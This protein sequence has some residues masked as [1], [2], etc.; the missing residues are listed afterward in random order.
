MT[1]APKAS[2]S[3]GLLDIVIVRKM[4]KAQLPLSLL[5]QIAGN[6]RLSQ[7]GALKKSGIIYF[8]ADALRISNTGN[9]PLHIDGEPKASSA[10]FDIKVIPKCFQLIQ[11]V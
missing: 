9:A 2:L 5:L 3:D 1:I 8:Q 11:P 4:S 10:E 7:P 6:N